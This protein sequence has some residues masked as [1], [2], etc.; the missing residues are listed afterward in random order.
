LD[1]DVDDNGGKKIKT[2][3]HYVAHAFANVLPASKAK[4]DAKKVVTK[5]KNL[6]NKAS[7]KKPLKKA[8]VRK[9]SV[10]KASVKESTP[11]DALEKKTPV[12]KAHVMLD[13]AVAVA[14]S[15][16][17]PSTAKLVLLSASITHPAAVC[18]VAVTGSGSNRTGSK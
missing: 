6:V 4:P 9:A 2:A 15:L 8:H 18:R 3:T 7:V 13:T 11:K 1:F 10:N 5:K 17:T 16:T 14:R 12:K